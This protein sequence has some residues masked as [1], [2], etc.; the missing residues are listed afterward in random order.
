MTPV[1][2]TKQRFMK[3]NINT[4][5]PGP[6]SPSVTNN[7]ASVSL[8][9]GTVQSLI[10]DFENKKHMTPSSSK[11]SNSI[12]SVGSKSFI[13][14]ATSNLSILRL[15]RSRS[16][17]K[18]SFFGTSSSSKN[19]KSKNENVESK[20]N[21]DFVVYENNPL[22]QAK[23]TSSPNSKELRKSA[24]RRMAFESG[25]PSSLESA[26]DDEADVTNRGQRS[27]SITNTGSSKRGR[28]YTLSSILGFD[29]GNSTGTQDA[30]VQPLEQQ[31]SSQ[32][33]WRGRSLSSATISSPL[34]RS[35]DIASSSVPAGRDS[36]LRLST[37]DGVDNC[38]DGDNEDD[39][40]L[41]PSLW[42]ISV[43]APTTSSSI[44]LNSS[45]A[46]LETLDST[47]GSAADPDEKKNP[48]TLS[49]TR[50][51]GEL[52]LL[53]R[54]KR[55]VEKAMLNQVHQQV[56]QDESLRKQL[57]QIKSA[58][59]ALAATTAGA[60]RFPHGTGSKAMYDTTG[61]QTTTR[62]RG[63]SEAAVMN[64][65][66]RSNSLSSKHK[67][68]PRRS[69]VSFEVSESPRAPRE[70]KIIHPIA[71][72]VATAQ[73]QLVNT[74]A[75]IAEVGHR[76]S[77]QQGST[78]NIDI[79]RTV[80]RLSELLSSPRAYP[81]LVKSAHGSTLNS[82]RSSSHHQFSPRSQSDT[83]ST[84][85][86]GSLKSPGKMVR[87]RSSRGIG[88]SLGLRSSRNKK[89]VESDTANTDVVVTREQRM[90]KFKARARF[91]KEKAE[92][93]TRL[94][95]MSEAINPTLDEE[96][97]IS[98]DRPSSGS[99]NA[100]DTDSLDFVGRD[101]KTSMSET[102]PRTSSIGMPFTR[103]RGLTVTSKARPISI[104]LVKERPRSQSLQ[105]G[106]HIT[107]PR[108]FSRGQPNSYRTYQHGGDLIDDDDDDADE[109]ESRLSTSRKSFSKMVKRT[110]I[111]ESKDNGDA[112]KNSASN[113]TSPKSSVLK[114]FA[115]SVSK[116]LG[117]V[118]EKGERRFF[119]S[120]STGSIS[121][122]LRLSPKSTTKVESVK[123]ATASTPT[124]PGPQPSSSMRN[125]L[126]MLSRLSPLRRK[127]SVPAGSSFLSTEAS[128]ER[129][130][131]ISSSEKY[132]G[133]VSG[134]G[135]GFD[136][137]DR[138]SLFGFDRESFSQSSDRASIFNAPKMRFF[139]GKKASTAPKS[140]MT[141]EERVLRGQRV[142]N[143]KA[144][145]LSDSGSHYNSFGN[146][147]PQ[148]SSGGRQGQM[149]KMRAMRSKYAIFGI[150]D[151]ETQDGSL[152][153]RQPGVKSPTDPFNQ[154][155]HGDSDN[156]SD[157]ENDAV[158]AV[159]DVELVSEI[160]TDAA[161]K[162]PKPALLRRLSQRKSFRRTSH[163]YDEP[164]D[165]AFHTSKV[166]VDTP[167]KILSIRPSL[168]RRPSLRM[169]NHSVSSVH[170]SRS[171]TSS[172]S[173]SRANSLTPKSRQRSITPKRGSEIELEYAITSSA[174][175][176]LSSTS[177]GSNHRKN[178][179]RLPL[180]GLENST[181]LKGWNG[182]SPR[183][184]SLFPAAR[185][186]RSARSQQGQWLDS[187]RK[188][189]AIVAAARAVSAR[190]SKRP[191]VSIISMD[192]HK[193]EKSQIN[194]SRSQQALSARLE[195]QAMKVA[196]HLEIALASA[197][198]QR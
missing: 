153:I 57:N 95:L 67:V 94:P 20:S 176:D 21:D 154:S 50:D 165:E 89:V 106:H 43:P 79:S 65:S 120:M 136:Q 145:Q 55:R 109:T 189:A 16:Q 66:S 185:S 26:V 24:S 160:W 138:T 39:E 86:V 178:I 8:K 6:R 107:R 25:A 174:S 192:D 60:R 64:K 198:S 51:L 5:K 141:D 181:S 61:D 197:R 149:M 75:E 17:D 128:P 80:E 142:G 158:V 9:E 123:P 31:Q 45:D 143:I 121:S 90:A 40:L 56:E 113:S 18:T 49:G 119:R 173:P 186:L 68:A 151:G 58:S 103:P 196:D 74:E 147:T 59:V 164:S 139:K 88:S 104:K 132:F 47:I 100:V 92:T 27:E 52:A 73:H 37:G 159:D 134:G 97:R 171:A 96:V 180:A 78:V 172:H 98:E 38:S 129:G 184:L 179:Q 118:Q 126:S 76:E 19:M 168:T 82:A 54:H 70:D 122:A 62:R 115:G 110:I 156:D 175:A 112:S 4:M 29:T 46:Y 83:S 23:L 146:E 53:M 182:D 125:I 169:E 127:P 161:Q 116:A 167:K 152:R 144:R 177:V 93:M 3:P 91:E 84:H 133:P 14:S 190:I 155:A 130:S 183:P 30:T 10:K 2:L 72:L 1:Y 108:A 11:D 101:R 188:T 137:T 135:S 87:R 34:R 7:R 194:S 12:P 77:I 111:T 166:S 44:P 63:M 187:S 69:V 42:H 193:S 36:F 32:S 22:A 195:S 131:F 117:L 28:S 170:Q 140:Y 191:L 41:S 13:S 81:E 162:S 35:V 150:E 163:Q 71:L 48:I 124:S 99:F 105:E 157:A 33:F 15:S 114:S 102:R 85:P 148:G